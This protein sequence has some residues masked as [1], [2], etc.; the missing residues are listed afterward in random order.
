LLLLSRDDRKVRIETGS[1]WNQS[2]DQTA[3]GII[4]D[5]MTPLLKNNQHS[6]AIRA[7]VEA[8]ARAVDSKLAPGP[9]ATPRPQSQAV[10]PLPPPSQ[11]PQPFSTAP[12]P[13]GVGS[14]GMFPMM[15]LC[16]VPIF[17]LVC[18]VLVLRRFTAFARG[19][20]RPGMTSGSAF[21]GFLSEYGSSSS[22]SS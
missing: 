4:R 16:G 22:S 9:A 10:A 13:V 3:A 18:A 12:A 21:G 15:L 7:G 2:F 6:A 19:S 20:Q 8:L 14:V 11:S 17:I 1:G 5:P